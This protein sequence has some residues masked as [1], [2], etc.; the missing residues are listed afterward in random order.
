MPLDKAR[1]LA[2]IKS[3][4]NAQASL[5]GAAVLDALAT[6][7]ERGDFNEKEGGE[8]DGERTRGDTPRHVG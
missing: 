7:L 3:R 4:A 6:A 8:T 5:V 1:L 2:H